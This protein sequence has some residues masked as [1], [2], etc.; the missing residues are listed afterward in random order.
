MSSLVVKNG[1]LFSPADGLTGEKGDVL[2]CDGVIAKV[3]GTIDVDGG[4]IDASGCYVSPGFIDIHTHCYPASTLGLCPDVM[5]I[6]RGT[7]AIVDAGSSGA[8]NF[9]SFYDRFIEPAKTKVFALLNIAAE[10]LIRG[11]E[12]NDMAKIDV[13]ACKSCV[14]SHRDTIVGLKARASGSVVGEL[15]I[16]PIAL[17]AKTA[18]ELEVPLMVHVGNYPPALGDVIDLLNEGDI[19]THTYHGKPGGIFGTDGALIEQA[20]RGRARGVRFDVGHG[21]ESFSFETYEK[22]LAA[23]FDCD[24]I[25]TDLHVENYEGPVFDLATTMT[26]LIACGE[27]LDAAV[28]KVT[29]V[30]AA[31]FDL[32]GLGHLAEGMVAD[33]NVFSYDDVDVVLQD[34]MGASVTARH[35][36]NVRKTIFSNGDLTSVLTH[37]DVEWNPKS[38]SADELKKRAAEAKKGA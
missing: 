18:H 10:G 13:E 14:N 29:S 9:E 1:M 22:A 33:I 15:G 11:H 2:V 7:T 21:I 25:S 31:Y 37:P 26:K 3:G 27:P 20:V 32:K 23:G 5:G 12:L 4:L 8:D 19:I 24:S 36:V 28:S 16:K 6:E 38:V 34:S 35:H 17:A 30:P